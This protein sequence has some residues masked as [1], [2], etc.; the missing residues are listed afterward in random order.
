M[1]CACR[2]VCTADR[3][4]TAIRLGKRGRVGDGSRRGTPG[5][6]A[7]IIQASAGHQKEAAGGWARGARS[8]CWA[9]SKKGGSRREGGMR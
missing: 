6:S 4:R 3:K 8:A 1:L 7:A 9:E 2:G 5:K